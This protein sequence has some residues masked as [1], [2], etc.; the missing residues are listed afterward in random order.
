MKALLSVIGLIC[1][2]DVGSNSIMGRGGFVSR[3]T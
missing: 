3:R 2:G 1:C